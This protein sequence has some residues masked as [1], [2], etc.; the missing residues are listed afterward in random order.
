LLLHDDNSD[1]ATTIHP[2]KG[3]L[4]YFI[5]LLFLFVGF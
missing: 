5:M 4:L 2:K 3:F 1:I